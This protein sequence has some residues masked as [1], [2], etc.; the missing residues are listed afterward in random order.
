MKI[1]AIDASLIA[2]KALDIY[3]SRVM[4]FH[5]TATAI[6]NRS[7]STKSSVLKIFDEVMDAVV[8]E[9]RGVYDK[10]IVCVGCF[11]LMRMKSSPSLMTRLICK[12]SIFL[13]EHGVSSNQFLDYFEKY[14][15]MKCQSEKTEHYDGYVVFLKDKYTFCSEWMQLLTEHFGN[16]IIDFAE[17]NLFSNNPRFIVTM[18]S[19]T[20]MFT[21]FPKDIEYKDR[22]IIES[23]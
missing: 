1:K 4:K 5:V 18:E 20:E 19:Q 7:S 15:Q 16:S 23:I 22:K 14:I 11:P 6:K 3:S 13:R 21:E 10:V 12:N 17:C 9:C 8:D 2:D